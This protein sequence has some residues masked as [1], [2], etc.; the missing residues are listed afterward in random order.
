MKKQTLNVQ[1]PTLNAEVAE[2]G[3]K[4]GRRVRR[5]SFVVAIDRRRQLVSLLVVVV[6]AG[7]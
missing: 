2:V 5:G 1:R 6:D 4:A 7:G 3:L